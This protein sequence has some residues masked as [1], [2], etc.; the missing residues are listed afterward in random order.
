MMK[1]LS[2]QY[3]FEKKTKKIRH[4]GESVGIYRFPGKNIF[5]SALFPL[6]LDSKTLIFCYEILTVTFSFF[7]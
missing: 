4:L 3:V 6:D 5:D 1:Q 2:S 7:M